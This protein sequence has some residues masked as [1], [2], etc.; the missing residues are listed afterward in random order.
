MA[1]VATPHRRPIIERFF[2]TLEEKGFHRMPSTTGSNINDIRR[3][4]EKDAV[5]D[6]GFHLK[7]ISEI[8]E[9]IISEYNLQPHQGLGRLFA[10]ISY[11]RPN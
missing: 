7:E 4:G 10:S 8:A 5:K 11:E 2:R 3:N 6:I 9:I 1:P